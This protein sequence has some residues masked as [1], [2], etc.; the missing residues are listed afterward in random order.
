MGRSGVS[1]SVIGLGGVTFGREIDEETSFRVLDY[2]LERGI[3]W[4]DT[5]EGYGGGNA[6]AYRRAAL[7]V[8]DEREVSGEMGS[9]ECILGRWLRVRGCRDEVVICSKVSSGNRPENIER[10]LRTTLDRLQVDHVDIYEL[11]SPDD[12][13]PIGESLAALASFV[14]S[15][16]IGTLGCSNFSARQLQEALDTSARHRHPRFE[17]IQPPYSLVARDVEKEIF[18]LCL[19]E[20]IGVTTY[21]PLAAGFLAGKY[22]PDRSAF[23]EGSR[24]HVIPD[25]ANIYFT[26]ANF[27]T[28]ERLRANAE[29]LGVPMVR[30]AMAW[31]LGHRA[32]TSVIIGARHTGHI[33]N[34]L[35]AAAMELHDDMRAEMASWLES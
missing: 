31:A 32:I 8:A 18:P 21:S 3:I 22:T 20:G 1:L 6:R 34:A 23:P 5:A 28:I 35:D 13:V 16:H 12:G 19:A 30:L 29:A 25:H 9:S 4:I 17:V 24:F 26:E 14:E 11:H 10:A 33:D 27:R 2:A 15:G 7:G